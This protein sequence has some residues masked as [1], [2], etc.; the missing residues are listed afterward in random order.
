MRFHCFGLVIA[1]IGGLGTVSC[2]GYAGTTKLGLQEQTPSIQTM[3]RTPTAS[4]IRGVNKTSTLVYVTGGMP[5][6]SNG[7]VL[8]LSY[9]KGNIVQTLK[10]FDVPL[11][12]CV[13]ASGDIFIAN[14]GTNSVIEYAHGGSTPIHTLNDPG[15]PYGCAVDP[16]T[17][18]VAVTNLSGSV[19][20]YAGAQGAP[21]LYSDLNISEFLFCA[22]DESG[23]LFADGT[24]GNLIAKLSKGSASF[25]DITFGNQLAGPGSMQWDGAN[26]VVVN[27]GGNWRGPTIVDRVQISGTSGK[28][29]G[30]THLKSHDGAVAAYVQYWIKNRKIIGP[31]RSSGDGHN[32]LGFWRYPAGG[33]SLQTLRHLNSGRLWGVVVSTGT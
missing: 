10:G 7:V 33:R 31:V 20:V 26:L 8:V 19:A 28:I 13:D 17:G 27:A 1:I 29:V 12:E 6:S 3:S 30:T 15:E 24:T 9:P 21:T 23:N 16:T 2:S 5:S 4:S 14:A 32:F 11:G 25:T 18:N 22:Y